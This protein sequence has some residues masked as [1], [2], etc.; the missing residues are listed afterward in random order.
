[1]L[2]L[3]RKLPFVFH[4]AGV[5]VLA[6]LAAC[7]GGKPNDQNSARILA[8]PYN[9]KVHGNVYHSNSKN[10]E[11]TFSTRTWRVESG[12]Y[13][14]H[15]VA[16]DRFSQVM[17]GSDWSLFSS[18]SLEKA[19]NKRF[20]KIG[21][22]DFEILSQEPHTHQGAEALIVTAKG[23]FLVDYFRK[24]HVDRNVR[25]LVT[26]SGSRLIWMAYIT[27][28]AAFPENLP[29]VQELERSLTILSRPKTEA[30]GDQGG[31]NAGLDVAV[32]K[33]AAGLGG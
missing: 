27:T 5:G 30:V 19:A 32:G 16:K 31:K 15:L 25:M 22:R 11:L 29:A 18:G 20:K 3:M 10:L 14:L 1:M 23:R 2:P 28:E 9:S 4:L 12:P 21:L 7:G 33:D 26:K 17:L 13:P 8:N 24:L 6:M